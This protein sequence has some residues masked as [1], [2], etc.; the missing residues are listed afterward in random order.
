MFPSLLF[1]SPI[2]PMLDALASVIDSIPSRVTHAV[3][4]GDSGH[5]VLDDLKVALKD[6]PTADELRSLAVL[7]SVERGACAEAVPGWRYFVR[8]MD[9]GS[10]RGTEQGVWMHGSGANVARLPLGWWW[11]AV[12]HPDPYHKGEFLRSGRVTFAL[13]GIAACEKAIEDAAERAAP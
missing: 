9:D 2:E 8:R 4:I 1:R 7:L 3:H 10:R 11:Q 5:A 6:A 13:E 12:A